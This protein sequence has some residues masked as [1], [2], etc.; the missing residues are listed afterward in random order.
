MGSWKSENR[1]ILKKYI[2]FA[3]ATLFLDIGYTAATIKKIAEKAQTNT[4]SLQ[5]IFKT[6]E[7][8]LCE[9]VSFVLESQFDAT[10]KFLTG[11]TDDKLLF[12]AAETTLQLYL[13]E[14]DEKIRELY[15]AAYSLPKTTEIIQETITGKLENIFK[16]QLPEL[17][18]RDFFRLEI[19]S[20]G[21]M[22]NFMTLPCS[23]WFS[24]DDKVESFL[25]TTFRVYCVSEEK[26]RQ[27]IDFVSQFDYPTLVKGTVGS[28]LGFLESKIV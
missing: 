16:E 22:R 10:S 6:K 2:L 27:A 18:T 7:D 11:K 8:I 4:G 26:I 23:V 5:N 14:S 20:G 25:T 12:Y 19:A 1:D 17:K 9:L 3:A 15:A 21:I 13:A 24:M 28:M